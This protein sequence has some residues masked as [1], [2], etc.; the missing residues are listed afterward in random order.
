MG[1]M[2]LIVNCVGYDEKSIDYAIQLAEEIQPKLDRLGIEPSFKIL[3]SDWV[4]TVVKKHTIDLSPQNLTEVNERLKSNDNKGLIVRWGIE[5]LI[6]DKA[7][8]VLHIDGSGKFDLTEV[9]KI[10]AGMLEPEV[11]AILTNRDKSGMNKFRTTLEKFETYVILKI[12]PCAKIDDG[13]SGCWCIRLSNGDRCLHLTALGYEIELDVLL[14]L[15]K[16]KRNIVWMPI[17]VKN[18]G[19]SQFN[20][21]S[22]IRKIEWLSKNLPISKKVVLELLEIFRKEHVDEINAADEE[23][24]SLGLLENNY[25]NYA[26]KIEE[27]KL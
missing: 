6:A 3:N 24:K 25:V 22:N 4:K 2:G 27:N 13:Q 19:R 7:E 26:K 17:T 21:S 8:F 16:Q 18:T 10:I 15:L 5:E 1:K 11:D 20:F 14:N 12:Y 9:P 23:S